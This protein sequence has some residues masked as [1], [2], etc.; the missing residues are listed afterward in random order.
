MKHKLDK[1][2]AII[3]AGPSGLAAAEA[4]REKGY[5]QI[6]LFE[7]SGRVGGQALSETHTT[8]DQRKIVYDLGSVQP[9]SSKRLNALFKRYGLQFGRGVLQDKSKVIYAYSYIQQSE[10]ANFLK[11]QLGAPLKTL[12]LIL[13]DLAKLSWYLWRYRR[14]ARPGFHGFKHWDETTVDIRTWIAARR[15]K[16]IGERLTA[17]LVSAL[18]LGSNTR[19]KDVG[20]Y[21]VFKA[22]YAMTVF[23]MRYIDG[24]YRPVRE[25]VQELWRRVARNF[26]VVFNADITRITRTAESVEITT[27]DGSW[28]FDA[29]IVSCPFDKIAPVI[30][31]TDEERQVFRQI[32]YNPGY[33]GAFIAR[34]GPVDGVHWYPDSYTSG[35]APP[36]LTFA[37]PEATVA[38]GETLYSC[39]FAAC[40]TGRDAIPTLQASAAR[41]FKDQYGADITQ[42]VR[43]QYWPD[44][45]PTY[46]AA[47]VKAGV[48]DRIHAM[49][50]T[51]RTYYTG[52]LLS[53]SG[54]AVTVEFSYDLVQTFF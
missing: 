14:L 44:Y 25:G 50:G 13:A 10:F 19:E 49:Q 2:I 51:A 33:R 31:V 24:T 41:M 40:P 23:P 3:G 34:N 17:M 11:Y 46:D 21:L 30:D 52:Q 1:K 16:F 28:R 53:L 12:P 18:T 9:L 47:M 36:Y 20:V 7:R 48:F 38:P 29:L 54:N 4:L 43:M 27:R 42:W 37:V 39:M 35:A 6:V 22:L 5:T 26:E 8:P 45:G 32:R 15:F